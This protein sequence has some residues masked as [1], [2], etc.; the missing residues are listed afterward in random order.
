M[1]IRNR[2]VEIYAKEFEYE[3]YP[4]DHP[5]DFKFLQYIFNL[6]KFNM[7]KIFEFYKSE[8]IKLNTDCKISLIYMSDCIIK[9]SEAIG[10]YETNIKLSDLFSKR[11][12]SLAVEINKKIE[13]DFSNGTID[14]INKKIITRSQIILILIQIAFNEFRRVL[15]VFGFINEITY[16]RREVEKY[17]TYFKHEIIKYKPKKESKYNQYVGMNLKHFRKAGVQNE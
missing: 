15:K 7:Q 17:F 8:K 6:L 10:S 3:F 2:L 1:K 5:V 4:Y 12:Q 11:V 13:F 16:M 9:I 14:K